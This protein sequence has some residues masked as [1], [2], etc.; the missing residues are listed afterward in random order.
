MLLDART[1]DST[2]RKPCGNASSAEAMLDEG[3]GC[4]GVGASGTS[5]YASREPESFALA[6]VAYAAARIFI[7]ACTYFHSSAISCVDLPVVAVSM[8]V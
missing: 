4:V 7:C 2:R 8:T 1:P 6:T 3:E 5:L